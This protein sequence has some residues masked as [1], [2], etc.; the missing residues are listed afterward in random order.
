MAHDDGYTCGRC[1]VR[2]EVGEAAARAERLRCPD[3]G[4]CF[5]SGASS[6]AGEPVATMTIT[7][8]EHD[9]QK[10]IAA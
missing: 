2:Y 10:A 7:P 4:L 5:S 1:R 3:C 6:R 9:R 8:E